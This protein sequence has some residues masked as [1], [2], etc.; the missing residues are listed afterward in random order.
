MSYQKKV[1]LMG[2]FDTNFYMTQLVSSKYLWS[3]N[4]NTR[5]HK[6]REGQS[7]SLLME[8]Y[9]IHLQK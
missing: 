8:Q 4:S 9:Y 5:T 2:N 3:A 1:I 7:V 6:S